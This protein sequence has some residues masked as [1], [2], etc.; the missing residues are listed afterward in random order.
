MDEN[1]IGK[2]DIV[3][4]GVMRKSLLSDEYATAVTDKF[5]AFESKISLMKTDCD[6]KFQTMESQFSQYQDMAFRQFQISKRTEYIDIHYFSEDCPRIGKIEKGDWI[7]L[8]AAEDVII[9]VKQYRLIPLGISMKLPE[10]YEAYVLPRSSTFKNWG[11]IMT[12]SQAVIDNSYNGTNDEWKFCAYC[13]QPKAEGI[14]TDDSDSKLFRYLAGKRW[15]NWVLKHFCRRKY[16]A[17][18]Y[19]LVRKGDKICQFRIQEHMPTVYFAQKET[20][21]DEDRG[22]LGSTGTR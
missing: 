11:V 6:E 17:H 9:P 1:N 10:M 8:Y 5:A 22:G 3:I 15:G 7:D 19:T 20:L 2:V 12:N 21:N 14:Y 4:D 16:E 13:L 18:Q